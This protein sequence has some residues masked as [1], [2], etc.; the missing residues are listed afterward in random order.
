M[1]D[2]AAG[3]ASTSCTK[4]RLGRY[5]ERKAFF[6]EE[7]KQKTLMSLSRFSPATHAA[8]TKSLLLPGRAGATFSLE[9]KT[10]LVQQRFR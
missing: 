4:A 8:K 9:R 5:R 6:S 10:F 3:G 7:K 2:P 1:S